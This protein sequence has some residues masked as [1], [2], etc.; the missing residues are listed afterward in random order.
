M[1]LLNSKNWQ[2]G[3]TFIGAV[4]A[5]TPF[6]DVDAFEGHAWSRTTDNLQG[7]IHTQ[8]SQKGG[9][10]SL[11][12][13]EYSQNAKVRSRSEVIREVKRRHPNAEILRIKLDERAMVYRVRVYL[14][15]GVVKV[16]TV[17]ARR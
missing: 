11:Q 3:I 7:Q 17:S 13:F 16:V 15:D 4:V 5:M 9:I 1:A 12:A 14:A 8:S 2:I 6:S 10:E